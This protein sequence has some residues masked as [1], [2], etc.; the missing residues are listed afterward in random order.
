MSYEAIDGWML[1][2]DGE[3]DRPIDEAV[4]DALAVLRA[5]GWSVA[6]A[7]GKYLPYPHIEE[8]KPGYG[9]HERTVARSP[10][11]EVGA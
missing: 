9:T 4:A 2:H 7:E 3:R 6:T 1:D 8:M 11:R 5:A 10:W